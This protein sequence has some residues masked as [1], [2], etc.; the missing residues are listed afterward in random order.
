MN[1]GALHHTALT[2]QES[3]K[4]SQS[5]KKFQSSKLM[6][7]REM[8]L[9]SPESWVSKKIHHSPNPRIWSWAGRKLDA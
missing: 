8:S 2:N 6:S 7:T 4:Q 1:Q 3:F 9:Q 5:S